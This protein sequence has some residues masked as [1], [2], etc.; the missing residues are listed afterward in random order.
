MEASTSLVVGPEAEL[1]RLARDLLR[2][3]LRLR[4]RVGVGLS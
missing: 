4:V 2:L 1:G 3:R